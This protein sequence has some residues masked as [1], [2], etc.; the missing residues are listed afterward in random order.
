MSALPEVKT[1]NVMTETMIMGAQKVIDPPVQLPD[2]GFILPIEVVP[3]GINYYR[4]GTSDRIEPLFNDTRIDF[5]FQALEDRRKRIREAYYVDQ[6][7]LQQ[8]PQMTATEVLQRTEEKMR[9]L[10]PMLGRQQAELLRPLIDRVFE[11]MLRRGKIDAKEFPAV[12]KGKK[13][14]AVFSILLMLLFVG[15][16]FAGRNPDPP[17][18]KW[19]HPGKGS[20]HHTNWN[21]I[22][23]KTDIK[24]TFAPS[25]YN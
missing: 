4:S 10:G 7:Q 9:L 12:I 19:K 21:D 17:G 14:T 25:V 22:D 20:V 8:G 23:V 18:P 3:G 1:I 2:D 16:A 6:L 15:A 13:I 11:I 24:N 5:G